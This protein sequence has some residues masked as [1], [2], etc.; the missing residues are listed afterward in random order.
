MT[1]TIRDDMKLEMWYISDFVSKEDGGT[2]IVCR[3]RHSPM[4]AKKNEKKATSAEMLKRGWRTSVAGCCIIETQRRITVLC[5][6]RRSGTSAKA[7]T[8]FAADRPG[9]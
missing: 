5:C 2:A 8:R 1:M 3:S 4:E 9:P 6:R 7:G